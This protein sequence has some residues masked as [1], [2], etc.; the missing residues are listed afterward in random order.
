MCNLCAQ[1]SRFS[2]WSGIAVNGDGP[3]AA[4]QELIRGKRGD[5]FVAVPAV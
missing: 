5:A 4:T 3:H 1:R 2:S